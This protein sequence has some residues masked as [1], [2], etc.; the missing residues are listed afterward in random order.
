MLNL[1]KKVFDFI[2]RRL[3]VATNSGFQF[4]GLLDFVI[5][6]LDFAIYALG[7]HIILSLFGL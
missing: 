5:E 2:I 4:I 3:G 6:F 1:L 7:D